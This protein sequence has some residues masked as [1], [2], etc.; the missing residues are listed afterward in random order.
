MPENGTYR[1]RVGSRT[2][3]VTLR[4]PELLRELGANYRQQWKDGTL[5]VE[6]FRPARGAPGWQPMIPAEQEVMEEQLRLPPRPTSP[7]VP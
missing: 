5:M 6:E 2:L 4:W 7:L 1:L 3:L